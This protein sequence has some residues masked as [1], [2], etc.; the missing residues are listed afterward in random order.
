MIN[1]VILLGYVGKDPEMATSQNVNLAKFSVATSESYKDQSGNW[2]E[3]TEW[4]SIV[5]WRNLADYCA[6]HIKK[7]MLVYIEGKIINRQWTDTNNVIRYNTDIKASTIRIAE[8]REKPVQVS[9]SPIPND[10][11][12]PF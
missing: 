9:G 3:D 6:K 12:L 4:H 11:D 1:K 7:G 8:R 10:G 5:A 2:R